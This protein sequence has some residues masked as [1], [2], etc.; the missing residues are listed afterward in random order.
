MKNK[1]LWPEIKIISLQPEKKFQTPTLCTC[2]FFKSCLCDIDFDKGFENCITDRTC[3]YVRRK[4]IDLK[5][6]TP[7][8]I[9]DDKCWRHD[10]NCIM[11]FSNTKLPLDDH[12]PEGCEC[13][14]MQ[15]DDTI[16][17]HVTKVTGSGKKTYNE[18][19][20]PKTGKTWYEDD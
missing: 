5:P 18:Y 2:V 9:C 20:D 3:S 19:S 15:S 12:L 11:D 13:H 8:C 10:E 1:K 6:L 7:P 4:C 17:K 16:V 14:A